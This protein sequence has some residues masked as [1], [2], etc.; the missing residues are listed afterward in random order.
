MDSRVPTIVMVI[1]LS[2]LLLLLVAW[3]GFSFVP[4]LSWGKEGFRE[5]AMFGRWVGYGIG[6]VCF[7]V[8]AILSFQ[9][10]RESNGQETSSW[11]GALIGIGLT[12]GIVSTIVWVL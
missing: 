9:A 6:F 10:L 2:L 12:I 1:C 11:Y 4:A 8:A 7:V 3:A 5:A